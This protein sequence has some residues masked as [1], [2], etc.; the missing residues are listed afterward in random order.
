MYRTLIVS[1]ALL[2]SALPAMA[3]ICLGMP[4]HRVAQMQVAGRASFTDLSS[5][6]A[7]S[8][9]YGLPGSVFGNAT[10]STTSFE[11]ADGS[12][13]GLG[14]E[15]GYQIAFAGGTA[16]V[17]PVAS[18][19]IGFGPDDDAL[20]LERSSRQGTLSLAVGKSL[21]A[22]HR[23]RVVP[24]GAMGLAYRKEKIEDAS[25]AVDASETYVVSEIGVGLIFNSNVAVR[26]SVSI[27]LGPDVGDYR[28]FGLTVGINIGKKGPARRR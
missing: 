22:N 24:S 6:F 20:G 18:F 27:P 23:L 3:Q 14:A 15:A 2:S 19:G 7:G 17:C 9:G 21:G 11:E 1:L 25:G 5:T 12:E 26:P 4:A 28:T 8:V 13:V 16:Q 10:I